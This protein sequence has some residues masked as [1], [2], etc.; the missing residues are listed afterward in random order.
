VTKKI[1]KWLLLII[2]VIITIAFISVVNSTL[3]NGDINIKEL[4]P[5]DLLLWSSVLSLISVTVQGY[6]WHTFLRIFGI[7]VSFGE[8]MKSYVEGLLFAVVTPGRAGELFRGYTLDEQWRKRTLI[9]VFVERIWSTAILFIIGASVYF[10]LPQM[11]SDLYRWGLF[12]ASILSIIALFVVPFVVQK[13]YPKS[14]RVKRRFMKSSILSVWI[15]I[16]LII[17]AMGLLIGR[18][19][20]TISQTATASAS[21]F[22][23]MQF[24]PVTI[25]NMGVRE[26]NFTTFVSLYL[27]ESISVNSISSVILSTSLIIMISNLLLPALPGLVL[28]I[29][30]HITGKSIRK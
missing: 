12:T 13:R 18:V 19:P 14:A 17:Q 4:V 27:P 23:A 2:K 24:M 26:F 28:L 25:A 3:F 22:T 29:F 16:I 7:D 20:L 9:I 30:S 15:Y 8:A 11:S 21:A 5:L 10:F 6:R 1:W